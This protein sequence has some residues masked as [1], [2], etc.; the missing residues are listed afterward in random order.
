MN[1]SILDNTVKSRRRSFPAVSL[2]RLC[3]WASSV[4]SAQV[5]FPV[6]QPC[7]G[8]LGVGFGSFRLKKTDSDRKIKSNPSGT[9]VIFHCPSWSQWKSCSVHSSGASYSEAYISSLSQRRTVMSVKN[10]KAWGSLKKIRYWM[11]RAPSWN[12]II[13]FSY[14]NTSMAAAL[15]DEVISFLFK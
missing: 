11:N 3:G 5:L 2:T 7:T 14:F 13:Q 10:T 9:R 12:K 8:L 15:G 6:G 1:E 4:R